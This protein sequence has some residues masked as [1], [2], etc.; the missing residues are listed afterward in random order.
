MRQEL[1]FISS[2]DFLFGKLP[3]LSRKANART[4][5]IELGFVI[6]VVVVVVVVVCVVVGVVIVVVGVVVVATLVH[7]TQSLRMDCFISLYTTL[8]TTTKAITY[9]LKITSLKRRQFKAI[10]SKNGM[11]I[12]YK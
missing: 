4:I 1:R 9:E 3:D 10:Y 12:Y 8:D 11:M 6:V 2:K 7:I 5:I